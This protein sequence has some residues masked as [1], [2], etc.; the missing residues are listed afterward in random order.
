MTRVG[1]CTCAFLFLTCSGPPDPNPDGLGGA[2]TV[3]MPTV[4]ALTSMDTG[5]PPGHAGPYNADHF[6][7]DLSAGQ[8]VTIAMCRCALDL[9]PFLELSSNGTTLAMDNDLAGNN[10]ARIEFTAMTSGTYDVWARDC[11]R[12]PIPADGQP[13]RYVMR[14]VG[15]LQSLLT[16]DMPD[17]ACP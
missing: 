17:R 15:G 10:G 7:L 16:C 11:C 14:V 13:R 1:L 5:V 4:A 8:S 9:D 12:E 3:G 6:T 2:L